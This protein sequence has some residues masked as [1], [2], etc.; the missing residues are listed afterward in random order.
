VKS[1]DRMLRVQQE[2]A[3]NIAEILVEDVADP[4]AR[5]ATVIGVRASR[6]LSQAWVDFLCHGTEDPKDVEKALN[7]A[8]GFIHKRLFKRMDI[9]RVPKLIFEHASAME[10]GA[11][12]SLQLGS[13]DSPAGHL[14]VE[15]I[16]ASSA[17]PNQDR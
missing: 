3:V 17:N 13:E 12:L 9:K 8:S 6:D 15:P 2:L 7:R 5:L 10:R 1:V 4:A 11:E 14:S 16:E